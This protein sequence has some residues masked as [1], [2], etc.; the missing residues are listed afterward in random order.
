M[1]NSPHSFTVF[2]PPSFYDE[3]IKRVDHKERK[4]IQKL[5]ESEVYREALDPKNTKILTQLESKGVISS[6]AKHKT[7]LKQFL[8]EQ[9]LNKSENKLYFY[10]RDAFREVGR[11]TIDQKLTEVIKQVIR[12][13]YLALISDLKFRI[14][15]QDLNREGYLI[16]FYRIIGD[17]IKIYENED[18]YKR[19]EMAFEKR[20]KVDDA[21]HA[22]LK[23]STLLKLAEIYP[24]DLITS[25]RRIRDSGFF[26]IYYRKAVQ[27]IINSDLYA[28]FFSYFKKDSL[29]GNVQIMME[30]NLLMKALGIAQRRSSNQM[31]KKVFDLKKGSKSSKLS[32]LAS[33]GF[34]VFTSP[35]DIA[36]LIYLNRNGLLSKLL[37]I[38]DTIEVLSESRF[39]K[40]RDDVKDFLA[41]KSQA[42]LKQLNRTKKKRNSRQICYQ[43]ML[44]IMQKREA[45]NLKYREPI[46]LQ[47][48]KS[49]ERLFEMFDA[50]E[51]ITCPT[52]GVYN[53]TE[54]GWVYCPLH[55]KS[56]VPQYE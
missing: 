8:D 40:L 47:D 26:E 10:L 35:N 52:G 37:E 22:E 13:D 5:I 49:R 53:S 24:G 6:W 21:N 48:S 42:R 54:Y 3:M 46:D 18:F 50:P 44:R 14:L 27:K 51:S 55:G 38:I 15:I 12:S 19:W 43:N 31:R 7:L 2:E 25:A 9:V 32:F 11:G 34:R 30:N 4:L 39:Y 41:L 20:K 28:V 23:L 29:G 33:S 45:Y 36:D 17:L 16:K 56:P 1:C